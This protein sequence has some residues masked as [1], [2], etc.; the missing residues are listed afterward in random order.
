MKKIVFSIFLSLFALLLNAQTL[1][2]TSDVNNINTNH[3]AFETQIY[4][5]TETNQ[6]YI[7]LSDGTLKIIGDFSKINTTLTGTGTASN[8]L[9]LAQQGATNGQVLSWNGTSW[10]P[11]NAAPSTTSVSNT[12]TA[13]NSLTTTVNGFTGTA[14]NIV[15]GVSNT[16]SNNSLSTTVNGVTGSNV[17][18]I[19]SISNSFTGGQLT[20]TVNGV[21]AS[22]VTLPS[23]TVT[24][25]TGTSPIVITGTPTSTPNVTIT[26]NNIVAGSSS[27][28]AS[29]PLVLDA[30]ATN[31]V[32][33][34]VNATLTVNN[35]AALWNA[36][37]LQG[38]NIASTAP[39]NGQALVWNGTS[40][41]PTTLVTGT[42]YMQ[43]HPTT[44]VHG[45][46]T[47]FNPYSIEALGATTTTRG[48]IMLTGDLDGT[49]YWPIIR[50]GAVTH[51]KLALNSVYSNN[52]LNGDIQTEDL[53]WGA[54]TTDKLALNSVTYDRIQQMPAQTLLG[55]PYSSTAT[56]T[57][58]TIGTGLSFSGTTLNAT[59]AS[60]SLVGNAGTNPSTNFLG[61]TD[62]NRLIF[63]TNNIER[64]TFLPTGYFGL[65][66]TT[67]DATF[68]NN[69]TTIFF[70]RPITN[71]PTGG[72]IET[73]ANSVNIGTNFSVNQTTTG[74]TLTLP[75][76]TPATEGKMVKVSNIGTASFTMYNTLIAPSKFA[77]FMWTG[78][79]WIPTTGGS[80]S[81]V[82]KKYA[83]S[84]E[85]AGAI[86]TPGPGVN[87]NGD[88]YG[89]NT[90]AVSPYYYM[91]FYHWESRSSS[92]PH[93]Y[94]VIAR[95]TL[96]ND[97]TE[98]QAT[99]A[100]QFVNMANTSC[101]VEL[102]IYN[103]STGAN[104]YNGSALT[105]TSW[106]TT[107]I[108]NTSLT[109]WI[110]PG[111]TVAIVI[112]LSANT[113]GTYSRIGDI[114]LNYK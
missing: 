97:F 112:T 23:G 13:P 10:V 77:E 27:S 32:V 91:N 105:N 65:G 82:N 57:A 107:S 56:P 114:I 47:I 83:L 51:D 102:D 69:G 28:S 108:A 26:R 38:R 88:L 67:P 70:V 45:D 81:V 31:A 35:T 94:Q 98:W 29:N 6:F 104:I 85:Y 111:Q 87:H 49:D 75:W 39:S 79:A 5:D 60:W 68:Q 1:I 54:V 2:T 76:P 113:N 36:N 66:T 78:T 12:V 42:T 17:S 106:T 37:Q 52:I 19:N 53:A 59:G 48:I 14:V 55:N 7:G 24:T 34:G 30:G 62:Y 95:V 100:I 74:Q 8:P 58:I 103:V 46:G 41:E 20:T 86:V 93:T 40:W 80:N 16:S 92:G 89:D 50:A 73:A 33:G 72:D 4:K 110:T 101:S 44:T 21:S 96:P 43:N 84:A 15:T 9:G 71:K 90:G 18:I 64:A 11:V 63:K 25:V 99:N 3:S 61:T 109:G 22:A